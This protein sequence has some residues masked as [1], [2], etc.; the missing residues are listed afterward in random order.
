MIAE[1]E[2]FKT[3]WYGVYLRFSAEEIE[4]LIESLRSLQN[5]SSGHFHFVDLDS[6]NKGGIADVATMHKATWASIFFDI[7]DAVVPQF[8]CGRFRRKRRWDDDR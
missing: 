1:I 8:E 2:D 7:R 6:D 4:K 5:K 3:G